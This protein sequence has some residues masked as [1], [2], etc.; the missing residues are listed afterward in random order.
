[1]GWT[2]CNT[3]EEHLKSMSLS[4]FAG[5]AGE[6]DSNSRRS[7]SV[8][9]RHYFPL[10]Q[11]NRWRGMRSVCLWCLSLPDYEPCATL[12]QTHRA[13]AVSGIYS[14]SLSQVIADRSFFYAVLSEF[15]SW[16]PCT[17]SSHGSAFCSGMNGSISR[18]S[19]TATKPSVSPLSSPSCPTTSHPT[20]TARR[21]TFEEFSQNRGFGR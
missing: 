6:T 4:Q 16:S 9:W 20:C 21:T 1:M 18:F 3:P 13:A 11:P 14:Q 7:R 17:P 19:E 2:V 8:E 10:P 12:Q 15:C 5:T